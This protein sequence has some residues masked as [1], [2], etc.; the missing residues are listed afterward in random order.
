MSSESPKFAHL[1]SMNSHHF[2]QNGLLVYTLVLLIFDNLISIFYQLYMAITPSLS[3]RPVFP[4]LMQSRNRHS[5]PDG[6]CGCPL[7]GK[8]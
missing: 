4:P 3:P 7:G 5:I 6:S 8:L 2:E 1:E